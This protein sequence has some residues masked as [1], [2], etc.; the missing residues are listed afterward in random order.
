MNTIKAQTHPGQQADG[1]P[2][3]KQAQRTSFPSRARLRS[4]AM[5]PRR[6][7]GSGRI[8]EGSGVVGGSGRKWSGRKWKEWVV[9]GS[10]V[11]WKE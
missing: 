5:S 6:K 11:E 3:G 7:S 9:G 2:L 4:S 1:I 8:E 10:G